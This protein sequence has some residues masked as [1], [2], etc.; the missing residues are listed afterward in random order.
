LWDVATGVARQA[1]TASGFVQAMAF[2]PNGQRLAAG[3]GFDCIS[4]WDTETGEA[5]ARIAISSQDVSAVAFSPD[6]QTLAA[7]VQSAAVYL[8]N[9]ASGRERLRLAG[10]EG[11]ATSI[12]FTPDGRLLACGN[13]GKTISLWDPATGA[14]IRE[15][16]GHLGGGP[17]GPSAGVVSMAL[18]PDGSLLAA[19]GYDGTTG[20]WEVATGNKRASFRGTGGRGGWHPSL[21]FSPDGQVLAGGDVA[22]VSRWEVVTGRPARVT[23][24][25][26]M[27]ACRVAVSPDGNTLATACGMPS[28]QLW[29]A[30]TGQLIGTLGRHEGCS[31]V[32]FSPDGTCIA[33]GDPSD[34]T[35][36]LWQVTTGAEVRNFPDAQYLAFSPDG[37]FLAT[38]T[39]RGR[40]RLWNART[41]RQVWQIQDQFGNPGSLAF[42][43]DG[44]TLAW[45]SDAPDY[46]TKL[47][48]A[49]ALAAGPARS[50]GR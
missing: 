10:W 36:R 17:Q 20:L 8:W 50:C 3:G 34:D 16:P 42:S 41:G 29:Q 35:V 47:P 48:P 2:S 25:P 33:T 22:E 32:A 23:D 13:G 26:A 44:K 40:F 6:G 24:A 46:G 19:S 43:A 45:G 38:G 39:T 12:A 37:Q 31:D 5:V 7:G 14:K 11:P 27:G 49:H 15:F 21:T 30:S 28:L 18:S 4:L 9:V 1:L